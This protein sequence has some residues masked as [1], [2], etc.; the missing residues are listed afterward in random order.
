MISN[1]TTFPILIVNIEASAPQ[2]AMRKRNIG[3]TVKEKKDSRSVVCLCPRCRNMFCD[4]K[5]FFIARV[6]PLQ[7]I[8]DDCTYCQTATGYDYYVVPRGRRH[9]IGG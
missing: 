4:T 5:S 6:D 1:T 7:V 3:I 2:K 8:K 9:R